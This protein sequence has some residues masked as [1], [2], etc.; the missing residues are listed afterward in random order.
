M[1]KK[2]L[3]FFLKERSIEVKQLLQAYLN[4]P[5]AV[6]NILKIISQQELVKI[7][8]KAFFQETDE[9][10]VIGEALFSALKNVIDGE[11]NMLYFLN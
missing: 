5:N 4:R 6:D 8:K 2:E 1:I 10:K 9:L 11:K 7:T 3:G